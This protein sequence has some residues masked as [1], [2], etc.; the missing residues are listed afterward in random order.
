MDATDS[1]ARRYNA[2]P[3]RDV[4]SYSLVG[5]VRR[6]LRPSRI[7]ASLRGVGA[8]QGRRRG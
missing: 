7:S 2:P 5:A 4:R 8:Y 3:G 6:L 1:M